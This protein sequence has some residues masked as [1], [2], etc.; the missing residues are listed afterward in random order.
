MKRA[1]VALVVAAASIGC[2]P[3]APDFGACPEEPSTV[4]Y[5]MHADIA[6]TEEERHELGDAAQQWNAAAC[7]SRILIRYDRPNAA[8]VWQAEAT[9]GRRTLVR[10]TDAAPV[11]A[12]GKRHDG[13]TSPDRMAV[14]V[15]PHLRF[16]RL[17]LHEFGHLL[18]LGHDREGTA[19][20]QDVSEGSDFV[21]WE[22]FAQCV[23]VGSCL[24]R[25]GR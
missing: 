21:T 19:M 10:G 13:G 5:I 23:A 7:T 15:R 2:A 24:Y 25:G 14:F 16:Y 18:G 20:H 3:A 11:S 6:F 12:D 1:I 4:D 9:A 22:D 17:A 8:D